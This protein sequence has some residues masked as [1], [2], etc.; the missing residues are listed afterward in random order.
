MKKVAGMNLEYSG[1]LGLHFCGIVH[2][3]PITMK[4]DWSKMFHVTLY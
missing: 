4:S 3:N 1:S 2:G